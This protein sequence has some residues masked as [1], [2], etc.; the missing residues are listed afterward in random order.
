M[1]IEQHRG[2]PFDVVDGYDRSKKKRT[3]RVRRMTRAEVLALS[4][5]ADFLARDGTLRT[6]KINGRVRTFKRD[7]DRVEVPVKYGMY[8][9]ATLSLQEALDKFVVR[10]VTLPQAT[11]DEAFP[12]IDPEE[13]P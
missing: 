7:P 6:L 9:Y 11:L 12:V 8:E 2:E 13:E 3:V 10:V 1:A 4:G 5:H